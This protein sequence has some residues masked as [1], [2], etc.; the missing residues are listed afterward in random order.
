MEA[1]GEAGIEMPELD[2]GSAQAL[3]QDGIFDLSL[4]V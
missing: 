1:P 4:A 3:A 2:R